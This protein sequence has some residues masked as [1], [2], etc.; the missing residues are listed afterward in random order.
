MD[1]LD[2]IDAATGCQECGGLLGD[3]PSG[4]FCGET[5]QGRWAAQ[6]CHHAATSPAVSPRDTRVG[7]SRSIRYLLT[8][9]F[10]AQVDTGCG[11]HLVYNGSQWVSTREFEA[12]KEAF[13]AATYLDLMRWFT[14]AKEMHSS[15]DTIRVT[16]AQA[17]AFVAAI[18]APVRS[19]VRFGMEAYLLGL[20]VEWVTEPAAST[21]AD[22][23]RLEK[24]ERAFARPSEP[25]GEDPECE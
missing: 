5:C 18:A 13:R 22:G 1:I 10:G 19:E 12:E 8:A 9:P 4:D 25:V 2:K 6:R 21:F 24:A 7:E 3:S 11:P 17:N 16:T 23:Y 20:R 15:M 14:K